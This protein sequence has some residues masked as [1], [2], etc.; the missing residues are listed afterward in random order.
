[1]GIGCDFGSVSALTLEERMKSALV[2]LNERGEWVRVPFES[3]T[4]F[5]QILISTLDSVE[6]GGLYIYP[7]NISFSDMYKMNS[8]AENKHLIGRKWSQTKFLL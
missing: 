2:E 8:C 1:M 4:L 3:E 7:E 6:E 5:Y